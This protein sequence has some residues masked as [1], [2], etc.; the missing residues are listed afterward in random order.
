MLRCCQHRRRRRR[1]RVVVAFVDIVVVVLV[2]SI[3]V[4]MCGLMWFLYSLFAIQQH[5]YMYM[6]ITLEKHLKTNQMIEINLFPLN[7]TETLLD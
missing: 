2:A 1:R 7:H 3:S 5:T 6:N 4:S